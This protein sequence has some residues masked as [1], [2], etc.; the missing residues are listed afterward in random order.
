MY[1]NVQKR[2]RYLITYFLNYLHTYSPGPMKQPAGC[3]PQKHNLAPTD[4]HTRSKHTTTQHNHASNRHTHT[5]NVVNTTC[6]PPSLTTTHHHPLPPTVTHRHSP[7]LRV[8]PTHR[9]GNYLFNY[10]YTHIY[11]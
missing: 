1:N 5:Y 7:S 6:H 8:T 11:I 2:T 3:Q 4:T 10:L 9:D